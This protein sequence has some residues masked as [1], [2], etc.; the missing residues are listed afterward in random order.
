MCDTQIYCGSVKLIWSESMW[1]TQHPDLLRICQAHLVREYMG[2]PTSRFTADLSSSS[3]QRVFEQREIIKALLS[4][5]QHELPPLGSRP[6]SSGSDDVN[7]NISYDYNTVSV[8]TTTEDYNSTS[9]TSDS[10]E[11]SETTTTSSTTTTTASTTTTTTTSA[12]ASPDSTSSTASSSTGGAASS[13]DTTTITT[14]TT[15]TGPTSSTDTTSTTTSTTTAGPTPSTE[16]TSSTTST[17][18]TGPTPSTDTASTTTS[19]TTTGSTS[20]ANTASIT[21]TTT[22]PTTTGGTS[23][24]TAAQTTITTTVSS[25]NTTTGNPD[26]T[27]FDCQ[28]RVEKTENVSS[29]NHQD[30]A[31]YVATWKAIIMAELIKTVKDLQNI[32]IHSIRQ[33]SVIVDFSV[34]VGTS[35]AK[36]A[37]GKLVEA[38]IIIAKNGIYVNGT[39]YPA[40]VTV[41]NLTVTKDTDKCVIL[42]AL[43]ACASDTSC[44]INVDGEA[45]CNEGSNEVNIRLII[46]LC[47]GLPLAVACIVIMVVCIEYRKKFLEQ[48]RLNVREGGYVDEPTTKEVKGDKNM[49]PTWSEKKQLVA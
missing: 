8:D 42:N 20:S 2:N 18:T 17:T 36:S 27:F 13:T 34:V 21:S 37:G 31:Q 16:T 28:I 39:Y 12:P 22:G 38:L 14:S 40:T 48:R 4:N 24:S 32:T 35:V 9:T 33:G 23:S 7:C 1:V 11:S 30:Y 19:T 10:T 49:T 3:G 6:V 5:C 26:Y 25:Q 29:S 47:V 15:T 46:G 43:K 44:V 45:Y 41:G